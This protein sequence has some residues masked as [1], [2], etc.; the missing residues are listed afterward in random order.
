MPGPC[1]PPDSAPRTL[2]QTVAC[3][4]L[5][6]AIPCPCGCSP[7]PSAVPDLSCCSPKADTVP[8]TFWLFFALIP[9]DSSSPGLF[10][11]LLSP[12]KSPCDNF[13]APLAIPD[14]PSP[15]IVSWFPRMFS[16]NSKCGSPNPLTLPQHIRFLLCLPH[17]Q[18]CG[19]LPL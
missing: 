10:G 11:L 19:A 15:G 13:L 12:S 4:L 17:T 3:F 18:G 6:L 16:K 7:N 8:W 5:P 9:R 1:P 14:P 2:P